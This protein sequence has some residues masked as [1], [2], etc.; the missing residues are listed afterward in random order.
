MCC[1][2][3]TGARSIAA[4]S[5]SINAVSACGPPVEAPMTSARGA[6]GA[7]GRNLNTP[8]SAEGA[9]FL[10]QFTSKRDRC[11]GLAR[12]LGLRDVVGRAQR[13]RPQTDLGAAARQRRDH[14]HHEVA[15]LLQE[16]R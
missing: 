13:Q 10:D 4:G 9:D 1:V 3:K 16:Q 2:I 11:R 14:D 7:N 12:G 15:L 5:F 8:V 6:V